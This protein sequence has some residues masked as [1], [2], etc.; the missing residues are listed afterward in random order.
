MHIIECT[1]YNSA[2]CGVKT[3]TLHY[4]GVGG[5]GGVSCRFFRMQLLGR[6]DFGIVFY[7]FNFSGLYIR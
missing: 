1:M 5:G 4:V 6:R 7:A 2:L 3:F